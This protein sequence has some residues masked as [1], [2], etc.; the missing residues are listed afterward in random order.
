MKGSFLDFGLFH[1]RALS[2]KPTLI[3]VLIIVPLSFG[4][5]RKLC[6]FPLTFGENLVR[7]GLRRRVRGVRGGV[8]GVEQTL[9]RILDLEKSRE[10]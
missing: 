6:L 4:L 10:N 8:R 9:T 3:Q 5:E 7:G 2:S 1:G